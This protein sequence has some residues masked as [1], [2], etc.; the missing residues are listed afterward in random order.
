[1]IDLIERIGPVVGIVAF[2][3]LSILAFL[4]FQQ[5]REIRRLRE[6][7]GRAPERA[8]DASEASLAA[9]EARGDVAQE[10]P[11]ARGRLGTW[12]QGVRNRL[13]PGW[14]ELDRRLPVHPRYLLIVFAAGVIAAGV[15][16]SGFGVFGG[17][18]T[19]ANEGRKQRQGQAQGG[20]EG[21][22]DVAV[23]NATQTEDSAG[24][25]IQGVSGL[26]DK[27]ATQVLQPAGYEVGRRDDAAEG[28]ADTVVMF[29]PGH[30][31]E[32]NDLAA[33]V[34]PELGPTPVE[35]MI[36][37]VRD[38]VGGADLALVVGLDDEDF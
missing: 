36:Q 30:E 8:E 21:K 38:L 31:G 29:E 17:D 19:P 3:G 6:W 14:R 27:V 28:F 22:P 32:A 20:G 25:P 4:I 34:E 35:P 10:E 24:N 12:W 33:A 18:D 9:A 1:M 37:E 15:V 2:L 11:R 13:E 16:T 5:A 23:L 26:A 7:A